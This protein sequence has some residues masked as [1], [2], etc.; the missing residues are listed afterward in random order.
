MQWIRTVLCAM[1][2]GAVAAAVQAQTVPFAK[3][4]DAVAYRKGAFEVMESHFSHLN[5]MALGRL[6]FDKQ[7]A[8]LDADTVAMLAKLPF[9]AFVPGSEHAGNTRANEFVWKATPRFHEGAQNLQQ[10]TALLPAAARAGDVAALKKLMLET[11]AICRKC[12]DQFR[13]R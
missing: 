10:K 12:H 3:V 9:Q 5:A 7:A 4:E 8:A 2:L 1:A 6:P 11:G 13:N